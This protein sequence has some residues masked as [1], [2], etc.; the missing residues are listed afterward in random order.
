MRLFDFNRAPNPR[1]ARMFIAEKG[2]SIEKV[3]VDLYAM[4]QL[5]PEFLAV[6]PAGTVPVLET[7][8]GVYLTETVAI[9]SYLE[10]LHPEPP[11]MGTTGIDKAQVLMWN[12]IVEQQ[13]MA[14]I[15]EVLRNW[16]PGFANRAFPGT[17]DYAQ[18]PELI[19]RGR[20][21]MTQFFDLIENRLKDRRFLAADSYTLADISLLAI[22]EF[23]SWVRVNPLRG[24]PALAAWH[25]AA[26]ARP[27]AQA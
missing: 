4:E 11:L 14:A 13:G 25:E 27:S 17:V 15:A 23:A 7:D 18:M 20:Q 8:E 1:R 3:T 10:S 26:S 6:N 12:N 19:E 5:R 24:R 21:R 2:I 9:A 16:S 22:T